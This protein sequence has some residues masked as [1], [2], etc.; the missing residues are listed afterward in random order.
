M[1]NGKLVAALANRVMKWNV[2][3]DRFLMNGRRWL[4]LWRFQPTENIADAFQLLEA[5]GLEGYALRADS[6]GLYSAQ[7]QTSR[8]SAEASGSSMPLAICLA[9]ARAFGIPV[10]ANT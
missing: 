3:P 4:P 2:T 8:E 7:V 5:A 6:N 9:V 10:E 1:T